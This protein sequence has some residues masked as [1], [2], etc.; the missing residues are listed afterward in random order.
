MYWIVR[1]DVFTAV[2]MTEVL[3]CEILCYNICVYEYYVLLERN[4]V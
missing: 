1:Y 2:T 3:V 4:A